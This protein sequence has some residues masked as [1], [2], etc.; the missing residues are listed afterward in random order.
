M[1]RLLPLLAVLL[2]SGCATVSSRAPA[3]G[4]GDTS[5]FDAKGATVEVV[6]EITSGGADP[7]TAYAITPATSPGKAEQLRAARVAEVHELLKGYGFQPASGGKADFRIRIV[8]G[9]ELTTEDSLLM[10]M[11]SS[12]SIL[13]I[14]H[15]YTTTGDYGYELWAGDSKING[16][17][18]KAQKKKVFGLIGLPLLA[19][20]AT[21]S[22]DRKARTDAHD[23]VLSTWIEQGAFE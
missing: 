15:T 6:Y 7:Q 20:N 8:E 23:S 19:V 4:E 10:L 13:I 21:G 11:V 22:V 12:F 9:G 1:K 17:A 16:V 18:T 5:G 14:P 3:L 2:L